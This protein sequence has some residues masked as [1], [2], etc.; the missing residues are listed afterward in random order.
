MTYKTLGLDQIH[1]CI[2]QPRKN[3]D[4]LKLQE[5][6][7]SFLSSGVI[8][9]IVVRD[10]STK[11]KYEIIAGERRWRAAQL[12]N[13]HDIPVIYKE[14]ISD[15]DSELL[16]LAENV[17]RADLNCMEISFSVSSLR[18][19]FDFTHKQI[20]AKL[21]WSEKTVTHYLRL[22]KLDLMVQDLLRHNELSFGHAKILATL[23]KSVQIDLAKQTI[24]NNWSVHYLA[25]VVK[26][27][28]NNPITLKKA[29]DIDSER[30][31]QF[32]R[33]NLSFDA[34]VKLNKSGKGNVSF[35]IGSLS[36]LDGLL[37]KLGLD[38]SEY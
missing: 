4:P 13:L 3:F 35:K 10:S 8:Q 19:K 33:N 26:Q 15:V 6:A 29:K 11:G 18:N 16:A 31:E 21:G 1:P 34:D 32:I 37:E 25:K 17:A 36:E 30:L 2:N 38:M 24:K 5:L 12:A 20:A 28:L 27:S 23:N 22:L 14:D 7:S 9:P